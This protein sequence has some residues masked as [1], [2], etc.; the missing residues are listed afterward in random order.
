MRNGT[1]SDAMTPEPGD[2]LKPDRSDA[3]DLE[4]LERLLGAA[5]AR[6]WVV[7]MT[8]GPSEPRAIVH[9][10]P[11]LAEKFPKAVYGDALREE[12]IVL[13]WAAKP[14]DLA[15]IVAAVNGLPRL[16]ARLR[17]LEGQL[18]AV[19]EANDASHA[20]GFREG[21]RTALAALTT[22]SAPGGPGRE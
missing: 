14:A 11:D 8:S 12:Q 16:L 20:I 15:L 18:T 9:P 21:Y 10:R 22:P 7:A 17:E 4:G 6:P 13:A 5:T 1:M 2:A 19:R 3:L